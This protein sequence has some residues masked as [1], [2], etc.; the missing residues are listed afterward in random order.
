MEN[1]K[2]KSSKIE[3]IWLKKQAGLVDIKGAI[4][5]KHTEIKRR[6]SMGL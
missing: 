3:N 4:E 5:I 1:S 6:N 2:E